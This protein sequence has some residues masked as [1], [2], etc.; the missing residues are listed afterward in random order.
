VL[1]VSDR[2]PILESIGDGDLEV[3]GG[4]IFLIGITIIEPSKHSGLARFGVGC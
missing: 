2:S 1:I 3:E 4:E